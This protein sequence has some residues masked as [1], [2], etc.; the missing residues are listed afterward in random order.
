MIAADRSDAEDR[1][2]RAFADAASTVREDQL[3][4][5]VPLRPRRWMAGRVRGRLLIPAA[6]AAA[7]LGVSIA[8]ATATH[9]LHAGTRPGPGQ[10]SAAGPAAYV[11]VSADGNQ[12]FS[13]SIVRI[14]LS[15]GRVIEP[16][17]R[18]PAGLSKAEITPNGSVICVLTDN[19]HRAYLTRINARTG[20]AAAPIFVPA[21]TDLPMSF[22]ITPDG[23]SAYVF[24]PAD[25]STPG[26]VVPVN[27]VTGSVGRQIGVIGA[28]QMVMSPNGRTVYVLSQPAGHHGTSH[29]QV[30]PIDTATNTALPPIKVAAG[31]IADSIAVSP[32]GRT[33]YVATFWVNHVSAVTPISTA[34]NSALAPIPIRLAAYSGGFLTIAPDGNTAYLYGNSQYVFPID[35][36]ADKVL[37]PIRLPSDYA[38]VIRKNTCTG[39]WSWTFQIAPDSQT[40]YLYGPPDL[41]VIPIDL[42]TGA[43]QAPI[44]VARPPY[45]QVAS[46]QGSS[47]IAFGP[48]N[49]YIGVGYVTSPSHDAQFHG[50]FSEVQL[51]TGK[52]K[53][54]NVGEWPQEVILAP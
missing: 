46:D 15:T 44:V 11:V 16:A 47:G 40:A 22:A 4:Q 6:A 17:L 13:D 21:A 14:S 37:K 23:R 5:N 12:G 26:S 48:G 34:S 30:V 36:H 53:I 20:T 32:D 1:L 51:A 25:P 39:T 29:A 24:A 43:A 33:V 8:A 3:R 35:L 19:F 9:A 49:L 50:A 54:I 45:T 10:S 18:L 38:C 2:R 42:V 52:I 7:V 28:Q 31:G 41:D 27:L